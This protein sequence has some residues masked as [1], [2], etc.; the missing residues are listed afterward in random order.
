MTFAQNDDN[1][2]FFKILCDT[3]L[4]GSILSVRKLS[5]S[6]LCLPILTSEHEPEVKPV[7]RSEALK[8][9]LLLEVLTAGCVGY[10]PLVS[11]EFHEQRT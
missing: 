1:D 10:K 3:H 7:Y 4:M 2:I 11:D 8:N 9:L 5:T 6:I